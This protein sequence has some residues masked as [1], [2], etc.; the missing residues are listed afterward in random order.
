MFTSPSSAPTLKHLS[1]NFRAVQSA[2]GQSVIKRIAYDSGKKIASSQT[3]Q[4]FNYTKKSHEVVFSA[5]L[6]PE[7]SPSF[8][9]DLSQFWNK[10]EQREF[11]SRKD[12]QVARMAIIAFPVEIPAEIRPKLIEEYVQEQFV[13]LG[14]IVSI[15]I[16]DV[17]NNPHTHLLMTM[18]KWDPEKEDFGL[19]EREW[20]KKTFVT[21]WRN[22]WEEKC[23]EY[24]SI[25]SPKTKVSCRS[26]KELGL[27]KIPTLHKGNLS[28]KKNLHE[29][30]NE[31]IVKI[32]SIL[33]QARQGTFFQFIN[34]PE[35]LTPLLE[36]IKMLLNRNDVK[37]KG[38][39][40]E[41]IVNLEKL[42]SPA[43]IIPKETV[44]QQLTQ[45]SQ[46][47]SSSSS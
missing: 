6:G 4:E 34:L 26:F 5:T 24:L 13:S 41:I 28:N 23:N 47:F 36:Q 37:E 7:N 30:L 21:K 29:Q 14:M 33:Q 39:I 18:R 35:T 46:F 19:K 43:N 10:V 1:I 16:H 15:H 42:C 32:N 2:K 40:G 12:C 45:I 11:R 38:K 44:E 22:A 8:I 17:K 9:D 31:I 27:K 20:N 3:K 25:Y